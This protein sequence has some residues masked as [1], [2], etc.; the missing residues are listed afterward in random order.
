MTAEKELERLEREINGDKDPAPTGKGRLL[1]KATRESKPRNSFDLILALAAALAI[2]GAGVNT[3]RQMPDQQA[4]SL[5]DGLI[6]GAA[7]VLVGYAVGR[8]RP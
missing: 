2:I 4:R 5:R 8:F 1:L 3:V 7:G 6:G